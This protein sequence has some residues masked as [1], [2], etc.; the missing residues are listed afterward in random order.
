MTTKPKPDVTSVCNSDQELIDG[1]CTEKCPE[2]YIRCNN[3]KCYDPS[4]QY[5]DKSG[6]ICDVDLYCKNSNTCC[7]KNQKC[8]TK[9]DIYN[10]TIWY[11]TNQIINQT[12]PNNEMFVCAT[13]SWKSS[14]SRG[15][16]V[17]WL[18]KQNT[19]NQILKYVTIFLSSRVPHLRR[20]P[21]ISCAF[22]LPG[23]RTDAQAMFA[24]R[25][26]HLD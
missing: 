24:C 26:R 20:F 7:Q 21:P 11:K 12:C 8:N 4:R 13:A 6:N 2:N 23:L 3:G 5:C 15:G 17:I 9:T 25:Q 1:I 18:K 22:S 10:A 14:S 19:F 16:N